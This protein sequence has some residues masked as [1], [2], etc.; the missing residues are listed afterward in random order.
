LG[1][2]REGGRVSNRAQRADRATL[3]F[4][5]VFDLYLDRDLVDGE[6]VGWVGGINRRRD[7]C[8]SVDDV[9][10]VEGGESVVSV[11]SSEV[12]KWGGD[13]GGGIMLEVVDGGGCSGLLL[14]RRM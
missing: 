12:E 9:K 5:V 8:L 1:R 7:V 13:D 6:S 2:L 11:L 4:F 14:A 10:F 3:V